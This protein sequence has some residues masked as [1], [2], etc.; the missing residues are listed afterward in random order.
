MC[1]SCGLLAAGE[2]DLVTADVC[3]DDECGIPYVPA[4]P[5][6]ED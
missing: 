2:I 6:Y 5:T 1:V 3:D 4:E